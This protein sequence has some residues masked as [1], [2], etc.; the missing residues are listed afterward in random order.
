VNGK[1]RGEIVVP[2]GSA[3]ALVREAA[4]A[5]QGVAAFT[6]GKTVSKVVVVPDR[7]VNIVAN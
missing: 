4:L 2:K 5:A 3:E 6:A 7:I 1:R